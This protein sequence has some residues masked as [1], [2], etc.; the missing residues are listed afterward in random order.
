MVIEDERDMPENFW[1]IT[2]GTPVGPEYD[3]NRVLAFFEE[4]CKIKN[5]QVHAQLQQ[6]HI[7]HNW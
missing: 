5:R 2:N 1:H 7:E 4:H 6:D 3:M